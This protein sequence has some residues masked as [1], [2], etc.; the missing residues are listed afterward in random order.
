MNETRK[1]EREVVIRELSLTNK[2][3]NKFFNEEKTN[4]TSKLITATKKKIQ[5][6]D[7]GTV[8]PNPTNAQRDKIPVVLNPTCILI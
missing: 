1:K 7:D 2:F 5:L 3:L 6:G 8:V 4:L